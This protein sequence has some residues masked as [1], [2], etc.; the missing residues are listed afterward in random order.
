MLTLKWLLSLWIVLKVL[1]ILL[2][3]I[4][5]LFHPYFQQF[6]TLFF[7]AFFHHVISHSFCNFFFIFI[8]YKFLIWFR[9]QISYHHLFRGIDLSLA[10]LLIESQTQIINI[11]C[12]IILR[13]IMLLIKLVSHFLISRYLFTCLLLYL[14]HKLYFKINIFEH[15]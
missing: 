2:K 14:F 7:L 9:W 11:Q 6:S 8:S 1:L 5:S 10:S 13:I 12:H 3:K 4:S 15:V